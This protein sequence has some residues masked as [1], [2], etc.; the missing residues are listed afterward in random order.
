[1]TIAFH[2]YVTLRYTYLSIYLNTYV[3]PAHAHIFFDKHTCINELLDKSKIK[4][5]T[6]RGPRAGRSPSRTD[7]KN[8]TLNCLGKRGTNVGQ[9]TP[10]AVWSSCRVTDTLVLQAW[11]A[12]MHVNVIACHDQ[13]CGPTG[14]ERKLEGRKVRGT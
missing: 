7:F 14:G 4:E 9:S 8:Y 3:L 1:M 6:K 5:K 10:R 12:K 2:G 13:T 11:A